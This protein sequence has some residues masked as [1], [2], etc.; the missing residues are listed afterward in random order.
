[1]Q[2]VRIHEQGGPEVMRVDELPTPTPGQGQVL[3]R[4]AAAGVNFIDIYHRSGQYKVELPFALGQEG[5]GTVEAVGDGVTAFPPGQHVAWSSVGGSCASHA[6]VPAA[7]LVPVPD[8]VSL[9]DA[10]AVMLQG[11]TAHYLIH[12]TYRLT[13]QS[14]CLIHAAAGGVGQLFCQIARMR[15]AALIV[16]TAGSPEKAQLARDAG[17]HEVVLYR[18]QDFVAEVR[19]LTNA[20]GLDVV[21]DSVGK[22]TFD[23]SLSALKPRGTLVLFGASSGAVPPFDINVLQNKGSLYV[24]R[25]TL[26]HYIATRDELLWRSGDLFQWLREGKLHLR[27]ERTYPLVEAAQAHIDLASRQTAGKLLLIP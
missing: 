12:S 14:T 24:T 25:P 3:V 22:D 9:Q 5:A 2:A 21:Y 7:R 11:M 8:G 16:G 18:E 1:M 15:G 26:G 6:L 27:I 4:V 20:A 17:A 10:A 23:Q 19:R 13:A